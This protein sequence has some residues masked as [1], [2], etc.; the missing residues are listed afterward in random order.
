LP[1]PEL[2]KISFTQKK[3]FSRFKLAAYGQR[4]YRGKQQGF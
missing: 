2:P 1:P 3:G 4:K